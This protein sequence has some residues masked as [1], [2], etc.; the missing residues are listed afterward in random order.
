STRSLSM[1]GL[2]VISAFAIVFPPRSLLLQL[3]SNPLFGST[4]GLWLRGFSFLIDTDF[5]KF[6][7]SCIRILLFLQGFLEKIYR[8]RKTEFTCPGAQRPV[9]GDLVG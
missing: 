3:T 1:S 7:E 8:L 2:P 4:H 6:A 9:A 5:G